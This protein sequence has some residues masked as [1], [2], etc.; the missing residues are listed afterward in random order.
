MKKPPQEA[1]GFSYLFDIYKFYLFSQALQG[2]LQHLALQQQEK[3]L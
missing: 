3:H 1:D 2:T